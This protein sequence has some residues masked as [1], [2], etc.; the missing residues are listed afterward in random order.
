MTK[1]KRS[2]C[3]IADDSEALKTIAEAN[4]GER[5]KTAFWGFGHLCGYTDDACLIVGLNDE[6]GWRIIDGGIGKDTVLKKYPSY[7]Y[8]TIPTLKSLRRKGKC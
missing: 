4:I 6:R 3:E 1:K 7:T 8:S 2:L 5:V